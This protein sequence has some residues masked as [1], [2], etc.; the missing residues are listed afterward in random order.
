MAAIF[1]LPNHL[2]HAASASAGIS[3]KTLVGMIQ[4]HRDDRDKMDNMIKLVRTLLRM[5]YHVHRNDIR[6]SRL[7]RSFHFNRIVLLLFTTKILQ[8]TNTIGQL[9]FLLS[10]FPIKH[11]IDGARLYSR[12]FQSADNKM[13]SSIFPRVVMCDFMIRELGS[14]QHWYTV[15]CNLPINLFNEVIFTGVLLWLAILSIINLISLMHWISRLNKRS[16]RVHIQTCLQ[17]YH[18]LETPMLVKSEK[19]MEKHFIDFIGSD[20]FIMLSI[21]GENSDKLFMIEIIGTLYQFYLENP[22]IENHSSV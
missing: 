1:M 19:N 4:H 13:E 15:Q 14:N 7:Q 8:L 18:A 21:I 12:I 10:F 20:G 6:R 16:R 22:Q 3:I 5:R 9:C 17:C 11:L 2:W